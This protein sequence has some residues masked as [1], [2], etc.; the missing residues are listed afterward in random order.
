[1][2]RRGDCN[3]LP[4]LYRKNLGKSTFAAPRTAP[5]LWAGRVRG[6]RIHGEFLSNYEMNP[7]TWVYLLSLMIIGI[8]FKFRRFWSV[9]N[10]DLLALIAFSPGL[11]L[12]SY[13]L[14]P[15]SAGHLWPSQDLERMGYAWLFGVSAFFMVRLLLD[16]LMV[17]RPLLEPNLSASGLTF[18]GAA[19][20]MFMIA[21]VLTAKLTVSDVEGARG[22]T[23]C[24][25]G[26]SRPRS[27]PR[28]PSCRL[29]CRCFKSSPA[30]R[31]RPSS[32]R[33]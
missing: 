23:G 10:L 12:V 5:L 20:L 7:T 3:S 24:S 2:S 32:T 6:G 14:D 11:L 15:A 26:R 22:W 17:R 21:N 8:Y 13:S 30:T 9:R 4:L 27:W 29:D 18:A 28:C 33:R 1:M 31:P 16:P 19:L 25:S